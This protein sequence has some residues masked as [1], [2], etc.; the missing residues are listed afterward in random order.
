MPIPESQLET[1]PN[2]GAVATSATAYSSVKN[3]LQSDRT[4]VRDL[5]FEIYLQG[6]YRNKTN[7]DGERHG[8]RAEALKELWDLKKEV[9]T[10][11][12]NVLSVDDL[13]TIPTIRDAAKM[14][15]SKAQE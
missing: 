4:I 11:I 6:S 14:A 10:S 13:G 12:A 8:N 9:A 15:A 5:D 1:W 7:I 2:L 3:A